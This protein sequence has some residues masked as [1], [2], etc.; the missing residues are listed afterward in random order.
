MNVKNLA[1]IVLAAGKGT[2]MKSSLAKVLQ[3]L[4]GKPLLNYVL[5]SLA[6]LNSVLSIVVVGFQ[7]EIVKKK[8]AGRGLL[9]VEQK[10]QLGTGHAAQQA[11]TTLR[12]FFGD[13]LIVCGDMPFIKPQT[14]V[15]L[16]NI[17]RMKQA[18]CTVLTLK[19][20]GKKDFGRIIRDGNGMVSKITEY[21]DASIDE[22]KV[23]EYNSGV[24]CFDKVLFCKALES[25][26]NNNTQKEYYL[27]DT[28]EYMVKNSFL[29]EALQI[30]DTVQLLG[31]NTQEDLH[32]AEKIIMK[33]I[34]SS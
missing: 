22:K 15:D 23:D 28:I 32:L 8:F 16:L 29:V 30:K 9:F 11:K 1:V 6:S 10:E 7:S 14:L 13:V 17:H 25:I 18:A 5:D 31:I 4:N 34:G 26:G 3:E 21:K 20:S 2:R 27:T 12:N 33:K 24:Y 19:A